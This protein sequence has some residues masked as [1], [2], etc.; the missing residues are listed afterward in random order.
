MELSRAALVVAIVAGLAGVLLFTPY[1]A[2]LEGVI[3]FA[4]VVAALLGFLIHPRREVF[5]VRTA[6]RLVDPDRRHVLE[7]DLAAVKVELV[8]LWLLFVPTFLSVAVLVFLA[9]GGPAKFSYLNWLFSSRYA[10]IVFPFCQYPPLLVL[11]LL[12]AWID[13]RRV[14]RDAEACSAR[15][16]SIQRAPVGWIGRVSYA[17]MGEQGE[18]YGGDCVYFALPHPPELGTIVFHN[19]RRPNLNKIAMGFLF[20]RFIIFSRAVTELDKQTTADQTAL[21]ESESVP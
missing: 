15:S 6:V 10:Y 16:F 20:H 21:V 14:M 2:F 19:V 4:I 3:A 18:Y 12:A 11:V 7:R 1:E 5:Y 8:R 9:A 13:E 17:F